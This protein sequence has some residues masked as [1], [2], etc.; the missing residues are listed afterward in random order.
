M[1]EIDDGDAF[2]ASLPETAVK[3]MEEMDLFTNYVQSDMLIEVMRFLKYR[4]ATNTAT[5]QVTNK[6]VL[7]QL[8]DFMIIEVLAEDEE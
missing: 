7:R 2:F 8:E 6:R 1:T 3:N 4:A 5:G